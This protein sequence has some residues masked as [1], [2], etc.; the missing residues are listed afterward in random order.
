MCIPCT[1]FLQIY[2]YIYIYIYIWKML[3]YSV[4]LMWCSCA[5]CAHTLSWRSSWNHSHEC[6]NSQTCHCLR[7]Q[8]PCLG[9]GHFPSS[10]SH[11]EGPGIEMFQSYIFSVRIETASLLFFSNNIIYWKKF[12]NY[13]KN[14]NSCF[15]LKKTKIIEKH[16]S[17]FFFEIYFFR[18]TCSHFQL[19]NCLGALIRKR[20]L[21]WLKLCWGGCASSFM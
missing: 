3:W 21:G 17:L 16:D 5:Q 8:V 11:P 20:V 1:Y 4:D 2:I 6:R 15:F 12:N 18:D 9:L 19:Q 14:N 13:W 7:V 10:S